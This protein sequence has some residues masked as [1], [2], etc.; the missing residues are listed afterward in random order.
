M[1]STITIEPNFLTDLFFLLYFIKFD[2]R[3]NVR[4]GPHN[5]ISISTSSSPATSVTT[6]KLSPPRGISASSSSIAD[7][8]TRTLDKEV[9]FSDKDKT[10]PQ[11]VSNGWDT[12]LDIDFDLPLPKVGH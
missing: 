1:R 10:I 12:E 7:S 6:A 2:L 4:A 9:P 3:A 5:G 8:H 11:A